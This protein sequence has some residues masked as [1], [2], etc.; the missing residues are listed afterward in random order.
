MLFIDDK[1]A[2]DGV[3]GFAVNDDIAVIRMDLHA[4]FVQRQVAVMKTHAVV[5]G[6]IHFVLTVRQQQA[7]ARLYVADET[8]DT[9]NIHGGWLIA[10]QTHN[11][12]DIGVVTFTRERQ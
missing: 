11:N 10:C 6:E 12:G 1:T 8:W 9:I 3:V 7:T 4:V 5:L 2:A